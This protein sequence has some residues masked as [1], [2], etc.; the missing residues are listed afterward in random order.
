M[1]VGARVL[2]SHMFTIGHTYIYTHCIMSKDACYMRI[3]KIDRKREVEHAFTFVIK[4]LFIDDNHDI[5]VN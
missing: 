5:F 4:S 1:H 3:E 2:S